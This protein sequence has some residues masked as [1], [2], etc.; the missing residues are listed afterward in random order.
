MAPLG[1]RNNVNPTTSTGNNSNNTKYAQWI[2][3]WKMTMPVVFACLG[4][5]SS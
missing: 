3:Q 2:T 1:I 5:S 4:K